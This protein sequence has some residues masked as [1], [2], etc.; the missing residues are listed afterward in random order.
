MFDAV[1]AGAGGTHIL[2]C[3]VLEKRMVIGA[4]TPNTNRQIKSGARSWCGGGHELQSLFS[5]N[6]LYDTSGYE[7]HNTRGGGL[8][9]LR[10]Y[11]KASVRTMVTSNAASRNI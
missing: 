2:R 11:P 6:S 10:Q 3:S 7:L 4:H 5:K 9:E 8:R 1:N